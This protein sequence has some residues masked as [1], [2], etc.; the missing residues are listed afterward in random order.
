MKEFWN[1]R[2]SREVYSY[3]QIPNEFL[4][5]PLQKLK[6][7]KI[8]FPAEGEGR[9]AVFAASLGWHTDA[10]DF[11][12]T[13]RE[14]AMQLADRHNVSIH[15]T[16]DKFTTYH[17]PVDYYVAIGLVFVH[18][19]PD[20]RTFFFEKLYAA[21]KPGGVII[22]EGFSKNNIELKRQNP[23]VGGPDNIAMLYDVGEIKN[24][25]SGLQPLIL[26]EKK[27]ELNEGKFHQGLASVIRFIGKK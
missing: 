18:P 4:K 16:I 21:L 17:Y 27:T 26:E 1:D 6:P 20:M 13:G 3:G 10:F 24:F 22:F 5:E 11:A 12:E 19:A 8:L 23:S 14:K 15:Y 25:F 9:N 7:G 2:Y